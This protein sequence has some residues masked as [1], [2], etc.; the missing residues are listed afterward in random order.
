MSDSSSI[1]SEREQQLNAILAAFL[2]AQRQGSAPARE[3][4]VARYPEFAADLTAFLNDQ[5]ALAQVA[6]PALAVTVDTIKLGPPGDTAPRGT[7]TIDAKLAHCGDYELL[8]E[9]ARGGMGVVF[10]AR[11]KSLNRLVAL[12][13]ILSG[14]LASAK[15]VERFKA[16][17]EAAAS[18]DHPHVLPIYE[19]GE[20]EGHQYFSM[21]LVEGGSLSGFL[22]RRPPRRVLVD[23]L[24]KVCRAVHHAHQRGILHRDLKP[25]NIL[26]QTGNGEGGTGSEGK[27]DSSVSFPVP[28]SPFPVSSSP[29]LVEVVPLVTDFGLAKRVEGDSQLTQSGAVVGTPSYMPP[30]QARGGKKLTTA[31]DVYALGAIL[32]E[33]LTGAPPFRGESQL[34]T[35]LQVIEHEPRR[36]RSVDPR[37]DRDLETVCLKCLEKEPARRYGSA[38]AL[39]DDLQRWLDGH[40]ILARPAGSA[41][42]VVKWAKRR[43]GVAALVT[44]L[45]ITAL[46]GV[47]GVGWKWRHAVAAEAV[48][49]KAEK[50]ARF[51]ADEERKAKEEEKSARIAEGKAREAAQEAQKQE[52]KAREEA[53]KAQKKETKARQLAEEA[54]I[55]E[56]LAREAAQLAEKKEAVARAAAETSRQQAER[57]R[58]DKNRAFVRADGLR[59]AAEADAA[60]FRDPGLAVL[61]AIEGAQRSPAHLTFS[62]LYG[63][64]NACREVYC[65]GDG[66]RDER[67][68]HIYQGT[69][70]QADYLP[71]GKR[72]LSIAGASMRIHD[73]ATGKQL[74]EWTGYNLQLTRA[75]LD[76]EGKRV[77]LLGSGYA[78][79]KHTDGATY[80]YTDRLAYVIDLTSGKEVLRLRGSKYTLIHAEFSADGKRILTASFDG[81]ARLYDAATGK[82]LHTMKP[83]NDSK[84]REVL[85]DKSLLLAR[86]TPDGKH[87]LTVTTND[88]RVSYSYDSSLDFESDK[89]TP[90]D[91]DFD[92][93]YRPLGPSGHG[94]GS[95]SVSLDAEAIMGHL[96]DATTGKQVARYYKP[97]PGWFKFGHV[98]KPS[99]ADVAPDGASVA[100]AL[101]G[102]VSIYNTTTGKGRFDL[103]GHEG[104][105]SSVVFSPDGKL[106]ATAG[107][108]KTVR[109]WDAGDGQEKLRLRGHTEAVRGVRFD[110]AG[111]LLVSWS[112]DMTARVWEVASGIEQAV[113]RGHDGSLNA[114][115]F[116]A[117]GKAV[118]TAG[119]RTVRIWSLETPRLPDTRLEGHTKNATALAYSPDG[120]LV[121]TAS[122]DGTARLWE[123]AT[124]KVVRVIG[125]GRNLGEVRMA[126]F[127]PDGTRLVTAASLRASSVGT[128]VTTSAAVVWDVA[129]GKELLAFKE[130]ETGLFGAYFSPDG[131]QVLTVGDGFTRVKR[132]PEKK[133]I[134]GFTFSIERGTSGEAGRLQLWDAASGKLLST[135]PGKKEAG[136]WNSEP[137]FVPVFSPDGK[138]ILTYDENARVP[139]V[140]DAATGKVLAELRG[141]WH[142]GKPHFLFSADGQ[143]ILFTRGQHITIHDAATG[144]SVA[145]VY[146]FPGSTETFALS[147]DGSRLVA[148]AG[149]LVY[150]WDLPSRKTLATLRGH[151]NEVTTVAVS[152][153]GKRVLTGARDNTAGLW[154]ADSGKMLALYRGHTGPVKHVEFRP[155]GKQ[156]ATLSEDGSVRLWPADLWTVVLPRRTRELT[157]MERERY[158]LPPAPGQR[159]YAERVPKFEP[160]P[161]AAVPEPFSLPKEALDPVAEHKAA[162]ALA[163][164][165]AELDRA[166]ADTAALR[167]KL[168]ELCKT[169]PGTVAALEAARLLERL[170][171]PLAVLDPAKIP[172][173]EK[174]KDQPKDVVAVLGEHGRRHWGWVEQIAVSPTGKVVVTE[175]SRQLFVWD[176][177]TLGA[178]GAIPGRFAGFHAGRDEVI[179]KHYDK[180]EFWNVSGPQAAKRAEVEIPQATGIH[181]V[182]SNARFAVGH[183]NHDW[184]TLTLWDLSRTPPSRQT[185]L[186]VPES[187][188]NLDKIAFSPDASRL[189]VCVHP[190][191][192][193]LFD[194]RG[195]LPQP[196]AVIR[197]DED[198]QQ[199]PVFFSPDGKRLAVAMAKG[200]KVWDLE[201]AEPKPIHELKGL[202][203]WINGLQFSSDGRSLWTAS[204]REPV[205][206]WDLSTAPP[207]ETSRLTG[208]GANARYFC[209]TADGKRV[210]GIDGKAIRSWDAVGGEW[211]Q[212]NEPQGHLGTV[213]S[214]AFTPDDATLW[215]ADDEYQ[216]RAWSLK[217]GSYQGRPPLPRRVDGVLLAPDG[218]DLIT[219]GWSFSVWDITGAV[220]RERSKPADPRKYSGSS[221]AARADGKRLIRL[222]DNLLTLFD[223][224][225]PEPRLL[226]STKLKDDDHDDFYG[227]TLSPDGRFLAATPGHSGSW[228][229]QPLR[230]WRVSDAGLTPLTFPWTM[231]QE[232][233]FSPDGKTLAVAL[234]RETQLW[235]LT[236]APPQSRARI[237]FGQRE[238]IHVTYL[239]S[240]DRLIAWTGTK[241]ALWDAN[242]GKQLQEWSWPGDIRAVAP[243]HD[244]RHIAVGNAN[245]TIYVLR[246]PQPR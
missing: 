47:A 105:V 197:L 234:P 50:V 2:E 230:L 7:P 138:R 70:V 167:Q 131:K 102:V 80:N 97:P 48:A 227:P 113:L 100:I 170:P 130:L 169:Y 112:A 125:E 77:V 203:Q 181:R 175:A 24:A 154:D 220:P 225:G 218:R 83:P 67:G 68:W 142:W 237:T 241:L 122:L 140:L 31:A 184:G 96:W 151:E 136:F 65:L 44:G 57:D 28:P 88:Q 81:A 186:K 124:G 185:V 33:I 116:S 164:L 43:P 17:A 205:R 22:A 192:V 137:V 134:L 195:D 144:A 63:A 90:T 235:D 114:A 89:K 58:D 56:R 180:V 98:W 78:P 62:S 73:A 217:D 119:D 191:Q 54:T 120:K 190:R 39:A 158:D 210:F 224:G 156:V 171:G 182:S 8:E 101:E 159:R 128:N 27:S 85:G 123:T 240:G 177:E 187:R 204:D 219:G 172:A 193:Q 99:A 194:L 199:A 215:S 66:G 32:Y 188:S 21:K 53:E 155:D 115:D 226:V 25:G 15:E 75:A 179:V 61:L 239:P 13:M 38:E 145:R 37:V 207:K 18:L 178:R 71:D 231:A 135:V 49:V 40:P 84:L 86:F 94:S 222:R 104:A 35:L 162:D 176:A 212:A 64:L 146:D 132:E 34:E 117:D 36:P 208:N 76:P 152:A 111:K 59:L 82:L 133:E 107:A 109:V 147:G 244:G 87:V 148:A 23:I 200:I 74:S 229:E 10:K 95:F 3:A 209:V 92:P 139:K 141:P 161:G 26:L 173:A 246:L 189:A 174:V 52:V 103:N 168:V 127:S 183:M 12:K 238:A 6:P 242:A 110:R 79:V 150:V 108:D 5:A 206:R 163:P 157:E 45:V 232:V 51:R 221:M 129:T 14:Q 201:A 20:C 245:G 126:R 228:D 4:L 160:P 166:P 121:V 72:V 165:R 196:R 149:K 1:Q 16:E 55:K 216:V 93:E 223:L 236:A 198:Y 211:K 41:E 60:R 153:D 9:I 106:I 213:T 91:P 29:P 214:L 42:R 202:N 11:Q 243:A 69:V 46:V 19:V 233:T 118:V 143:R 30:E